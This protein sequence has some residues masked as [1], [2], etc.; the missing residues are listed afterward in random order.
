MITDEYD[1]REHYEG[2][3]T[4]VSDAG[5]EQYNEFRNAATRPVPNPCA[6]RP[7]DETLVTFDPPAYKVSGLMPCHVPGCMAEIWGFLALVLHVRTSHPN[8]PA[9]LCAWCAAPFVSHA[10]CRAHEI[11]A[12]KHQFRLASKKLGEKVKEIEA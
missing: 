1:A 4:T 12:H 8:H 3:D 2:V 7:I 6:H 10:L 11:A 9:V 5:H